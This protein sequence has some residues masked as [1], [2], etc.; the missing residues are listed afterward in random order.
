MVACRVRNQDLGQDPGSTPCRFGVAAFGVRGRVNYCNQHEIIHANPYPCHDIS[1]TMLVNWGPCHPHEQDYQLINLMLITLMTLYAMSWNVSQNVFQVLFFGV[2]SVI[3]VFVIHYTT[4]R[5]ISVTKYNS[6]RPSQNGH[7][8]PDVIF[9]YIFLNEIW[10]EISLEFVPRNSIN[11]ISALVQI[12]ACADQ[13]TSFYLNRWWSNH[14]WMPTSL[15]LNELNNM[16]ILMW[17]RAWVS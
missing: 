11:Y 1:W 4:I 10:I 7:H 6:L 2:T 3:A 15:G 8:L 13:A 5:I 16:D 17:V 14:W 9:K 12:M